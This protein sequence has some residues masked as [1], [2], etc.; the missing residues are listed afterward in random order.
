MT[1][2]ASGF[3]RRWIALAIAAAIPLLAL[4]EYSIR[5]AMPSFDPSNHLR[6]EPARD[7]RP[8]LGRPGT[9]RH[10]NN[11]G[12]YDV[13]VTFNRHGFRDRKDLVQSTPRDIFVVGDSFAFGWGVAEDDRFS[14]RLE[15]MLGQPV[16][17][18]AT[19]ANIPD[20]PD[21]IAYAL[22]AGAKIGRV[23][24]AVNMYD[25]LALPAPRDGPAA[26]KPDFGFPAVK[27]LLLKNSAFY[28]LVTHL[29]HKYRSLKEFLVGAGVIA[30]VAALRAPVLDDRSIRHSAG[31]FADL[32]ARFDLT[33]LLI[34]DSSRWTA[35]NRG[36]AVKTH[37]LF[38]AELSRRGIRVV[39]LVPAF[40]AGG[41]PL[42]Y[43]FSGDRHWTPAGHELAA[44]LLAAALRS[45]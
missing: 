43:Q 42:R 16:Y 9:Q 40:E 12:D 24:V 3:A 20:Y 23:V 2:P 33:V 31:V 44:R 10:I 11:V 32:S 5:L 30:P 17:N 1:G 21:L 27:D 28:F 36:D 19:P 35:A 39:D 38:A 6:F 25:D 29:A 7:G 13:S 18:I 14:N 15:R 45:R 37:A 8:T 22:R 34:P 41:S 4:A 26:E